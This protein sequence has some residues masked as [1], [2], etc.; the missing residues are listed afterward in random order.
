MGMFAFDLIIYVTILF[1]LNYELGKGHCFGLAELFSRWPVRQTVD[2]EAGQL[3][4]G[5]WQQVEV[6]YYFSGFLLTHKVQNFY[7]VE[8]QTDG[9]ELDL[10]G[11]F[12]INLRGQHKYWR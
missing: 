3:F 11:R 5:A 4:L 12:T 7:T 8:E 2:S 9:C 1:E 10:E 6:L